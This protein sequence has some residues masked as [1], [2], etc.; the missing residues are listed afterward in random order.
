MLWYTDINQ[1]C[2]W[3]CIH[4]KYAKYFHS[5]FHTNVKRNVMRKLGTF[6][7]DSFHFISS[8]TFVWIHLTSQGTIST[9][10]QHCIG[11]IYG[12]CKLV[13]EYLHYIVKLRLG[14][15]AE[16][17]MISI[18]LCI[19]FGCFGTFIKFSYNFHPLFIHTFPHERAI[20]CKMHWKSMCIAANNSYITY[21]FDI[22]IRL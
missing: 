9:W 11:F 3:K 14:I 12:F 6:V 20:A 22:N 10:S 1:M 21:I 17:W 5:E 16:E 4:S 13:V 19:I 18:Q 2:I 15:L 7:M 8:S